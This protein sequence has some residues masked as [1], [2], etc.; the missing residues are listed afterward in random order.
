M[1]IQYL[2]T[3]ILF[4]ISG[5]LYAIAAYRHYKYKHTYLLCKC[6]THSTLSFTACFLAILLCFSIQSKPLGL[7][8]MAISCLIIALIYLF[9]KKVKLAIIPGLFCIG[10][11]IFSIII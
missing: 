11:L 5:F 9:S 2:I 4:G 1:K 6:T 10:F 8:V 7:G 3:A